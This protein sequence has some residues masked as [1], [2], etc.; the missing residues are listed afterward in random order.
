MEDIKSF[1]SLPYDFELDDSIVSK[2][3]NNS[4]EEWYAQELERMRAFK[5]N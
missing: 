5:W 3:N 2:F 4:T 1:I